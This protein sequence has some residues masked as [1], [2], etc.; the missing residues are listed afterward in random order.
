MEVDA[1]DY[2]FRESVDRQ[3]EEARLDENLSATSDARGNLAAAREHTQS[4]QVELHSAL[5]VIK[6]AEEKAAETAEHTKSLEAELSHTRKVLKES[7]ERAAAVEA[8]CAEV[9]K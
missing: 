3:I 9:L 6:K 1:R 5:E 8:H 4:L 2:S 7:D